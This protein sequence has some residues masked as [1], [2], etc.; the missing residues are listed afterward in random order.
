MGTSIIKLSILLISIIFI[1]SCQEDYNERYL[2][3]ENSIELEDAI[4]TTLVPGKPYGIVKRKIGAA[5]AVTLQVNMF[6]VPHN[7]DQSFSFRVVEDEST[8]ISG[9]D[10]LL[11][12]GNT[13]IIPK[14]SNKGFIQIN[15]VPSG[16]GRSLLVLEIL[17]NEQIKVAQNYKLIAIECQY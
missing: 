16:A 14:N 10:Y 1:S 13:F 9:K 12:N 17:G 2:I 3:K 5:S 11:P 6:G 4:T 15:G 8:A 7:Q